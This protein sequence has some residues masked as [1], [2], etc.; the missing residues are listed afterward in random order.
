VCTIGLGPVQFKP[1]GPQNDVHTSGRSRTC[2]RK[3]AKVQTA[4]ALDF[5]RESGSYPRQES[6]LRTRFRKPL[7]P[8]PDVALLVTLLA[9][10]LDVVNAFRMTRLSDP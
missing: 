6:N 8:E 4:Y 9:A 10:L 1:M 5:R 2:A 7:Q 3:P